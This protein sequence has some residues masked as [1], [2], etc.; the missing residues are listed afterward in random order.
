MYLQFSLKKELW[1]AI[2]LFLSHHFGKYIIFGDFNVASAP[3]ER[4]GLDFYGN[5][6]NEFN[7]CIIDKD[8]TD[9]PMGGRRF[10]RVDRLLKMEKIDRF[11][12]FNGVLEHIFPSMAGLVLP[13]L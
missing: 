8:L 1:D 9:V 2:A 6:A 10:T 11:L 5:D 7:S 3:N 12:I 4:N 13:R